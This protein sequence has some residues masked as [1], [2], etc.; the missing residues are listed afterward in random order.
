MWLLHN[1]KQLS[2]RS[3]SLF[4][5]VQRASLMTTDSQ[6]MNWAMTA[7]QVCSIMN[8]PYILSCIKIPY[9][10][11][12]LN[13]QGIDTALHQSFTHSNR[14]C[15]VFRPTI[16]IPLRCQLPPPG[17]AARGT[18]CAHFARFGSSCRFILRM[19]YCS[20][21]TSFPAAIRPASFDIPA[22]EA[23]PKQSVLVCIFHGSNARYGAGSTA[24]H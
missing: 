13:T 2:A 1:Q 6:H 8:G 5:H 20:Y 16:F 14:T 4:S 7:G 9:Y 21:L 24:R 11:L 15:P 18:G 3:F 10:R 19:L 17:M 22:G 12:I 23:T